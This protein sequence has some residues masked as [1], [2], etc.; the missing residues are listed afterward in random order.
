MESVV[1]LI[2]LVV[3]ALSWLS[4]MR[5]RESAVAA[6][7]QACKAYEV[8]LLDGTVALGALNLRKTPEGLRFRRVYQF[9]FSR[10]GVDRANGRITLVGSQVEVIYFDPPPVT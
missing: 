2:L 8:Q 10:S 7:A 3:L 6:C 1:L 9:A 4:A 5:A